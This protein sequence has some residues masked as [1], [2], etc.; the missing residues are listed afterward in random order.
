[1]PA[2]VTKT[3]NKFH[4]NLPQIWR[5]SAATSGSEEL[6]KVCDELVD[7][8]RAILLEQR[9]VWTPLNPKYLHKKIREGYD[10]RIL[11]R[12]K[13]Y[14]ESIAVFTEPA[15]NLSAAFRVGVPDE[16]IHNSGMTFRKLAGV[17]EY[18][19]RDG[20]IPARPHWRPTW[21]TFVTS[22]QEVS[23]RL[24]KRI[25]ADFREKIR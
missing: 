17:H 11:I 25:L 5:E 1:M 9:Y 8:M 16:K 13:E 24:G 4:K 15:A 18:G 22:L 7:L 20:K 21:S 23:K 19:R 3:R 12:T 6:R 2:K 14:V 10:P